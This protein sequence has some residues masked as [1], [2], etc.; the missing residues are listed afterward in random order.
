MARKP[1]LNLSSTYLRRRP[2]SSIE[3]LT[4]GNRFRDRLAAREL[5]RFRLEYLIA[6]H[7]FESDW[8]L[9]E[10]HPGGDEV[11]CLVFHR[12]RRGHAAPAGLTRGRRAF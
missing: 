10:M 7:A 9:W 1:A 8:T 2:D 6:M 3:Q 5:G 12:R 11:V 4:A